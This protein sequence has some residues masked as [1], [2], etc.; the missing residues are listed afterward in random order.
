LKVAF[1]GQEN[2]LSDTSNGK[3]SL[4]NQPTGRQAKKQGFCFY[5]DKKIIFIF[6]ARQLFD[7]FFFTV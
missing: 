2:I 6:G 1:G 3:I 7:D 5:S 4:T